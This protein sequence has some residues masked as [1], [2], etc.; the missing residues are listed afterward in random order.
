MPCALQCRHVAKQEIVQEEST[1]CK[2]RPKSFFPNFFG[3]SF[4][5]IKTVHEITN[6]RTKCCFHDKP[7]HMWWYCD[8]SKRQIKLFH[9]N[10]VIQI[11]LYVCIHF[12]VSVT[13]LFV[14]KRKEKRAQPCL[15][16]RGGGQPN[17]IFSLK[18]LLLLI[19]I[20][21]FT[22]WN[23]LSIYPTMLPWVLWH[24]HTLV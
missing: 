16:K 17:N 4:K 9:F 14:K 10:Y 21:D 23:I 22:G 1:A 8:T 20:F 24:P 18:V 2:A 19:F 15:L 6:N 13:I 11:C 7:T 12:V 3:W 5:N